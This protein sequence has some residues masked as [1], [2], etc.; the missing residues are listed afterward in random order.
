MLF[1]EGNHV[2]SVCVANGHCELQTLAQQHEIDYVSLPY[3]YPQRKV[4]ASHERFVFDHNRCVLCTRCVRV[5]DEVEG[6]H[7]WDI[8]GRGIESAMMTDLNQPWGTSVTC[9]SCGKCV[10]ACP[11][12]A[13]F[14][15]GKSVGEMVHSPAF[16]TFLAQMRETKK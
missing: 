1:T 7:T 5:C 2:C 9:T 12:G 11:T 6:A 15:K 10:Q 14:M 3:L 13:L 16:L 8:R 4:D